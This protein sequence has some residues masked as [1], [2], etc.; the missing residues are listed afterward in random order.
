MPAWT[1]SVEF[2]Q[3]GEDATAAAVNRASRALESRTNY[4]KTRQD[5]AEAGETLITYDAA[6]HPDLLVGQPVYWNADSLRFEAAVAAAVVEEGELRASPASAC[7]GVVYRKELADKGW[8]LLAGR[9][10]LD[11]ANAVDGEILPGF[12]YL[13]GAVAGKLVR[14]SQPVTVSVLCADGAGTVYVLPQARNVLDAHVHYRFELTCRPAGS[15]DQPEVGGRHVIKTANPDFPGWLPAAGMAGA[16]PHAAFGYNLEAHPELKAAWPPVPATEA[17]LVWFK[18]DGSGGTQVADGASGLVVF[19]ARGIWWMSDCYGD[20]PWPTATSTSNS[21]YPAEPEKPSSAG[22]ECGRWDGMRLQ[23]YFSHPRFATDRAAV[24]SLESR[25]GSP[26]SFVDAVSGL[27]ATSGALVALFE[28]EN[29]VASSDNDGGVAFKALDSSG[30]FLVGWVAEGVRSGN[31]NLTVS[32]TRTKTIGGL[33]Y[34]QGLLTLTANFEPPTR[35]LP[36]SVARLNDVRERYYNELL[37]LGFPAG[38][39]SDVRV[40]LR[41]PVAGLP[42]NPKL[43]LRTQVLGRAAGT[44]PDL[45]VSYRVVPAAPANTALPLTDSALGYA[46][47]GAIGVDEYR[48]VDSDGFTVAAGD[49]VFLSIAR[50]A[51]DGYGGEVGLLDVT[52]LLY[53]G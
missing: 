24:T 31:S 30:R 3:N 10:E 32:G 50:S 48:Q 15:A 21:S 47:S 17:S 20:V 22:P 40:K 12:Y 4:L 6:L 19:N 25:S 28:A 29:R 46:S 34:H 51:S 14:Q 11:L 16:P 39:E 36:L 18:G 35:D 53:A 49:V 52:G 23:L 1:N 5:L 27:P 43:R 41:I 26:I 8:V 13:S 9:A 38:Q 2:A 37:Y 33:S 44:L 42:A 7:V 45:G